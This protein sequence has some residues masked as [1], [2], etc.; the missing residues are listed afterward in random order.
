MKK[1]SIIVGAL[2]VFG[3]ASCKKD[4]SCDCIL[5]NETSA[6]QYDGYTKSDAEDGCSKCEE[7]LKVTDSGASCTLTKK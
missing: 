4:Y 1:V 7:T 2:F 6:T 5:T 3:M